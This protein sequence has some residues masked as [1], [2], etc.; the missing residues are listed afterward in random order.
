MKARPTSARIAAAAAR[1]LEREGLAAVS[2]RRIARELGITP[3]ALYHHYRNRKAL[4]D[5]VADAEFA[6]LKAISDRKLARRGARGDL[7][8]AVDAYLDYALARPHAFDYVFNTRRA[9][10]R[11]FP[12]DFRAGRSPTLTPVADE[13]EAAMQSGTIRR[14]DRWEIALQLWAQAHGYVA[15]Y[16][17]GRFEQGEKAFRALYHRAV[18]RL[19]DGL[20]V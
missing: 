2:M 1:I 8:R 12:T 13:L 17:A 18:Q 10:A 14:G 19:L 15:L 11:R 20:K 5:A 3:M 4:L 6:R 16:R 9:G 7:I